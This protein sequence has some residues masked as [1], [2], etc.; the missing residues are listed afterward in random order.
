MLSGLLFPYIY[1]KGHSSFRL[2]LPLPA[3]LVLLT[4]PPLRRRSQFLSPD[5]FLSGLLLGLLLLSG[6]LL[7]LLLLSELLLGLLLF[8]L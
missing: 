3:S 8:N 5:L 2:F 7:G 1:P 6:L 4:H